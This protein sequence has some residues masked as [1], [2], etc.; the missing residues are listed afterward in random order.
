MGTLQTPWT[1]LVDK[2]D[3]EVNIPRTTTI[4]EPWMDGMVVMD[5]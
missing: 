3:L 5:M 4:S 1:V 2:S